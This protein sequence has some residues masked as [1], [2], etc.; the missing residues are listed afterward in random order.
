MAAFGAPVKAA[1]LWPP[2]SAINPLTG[3]ADRNPPANREIDGPHIAEWLST[4]HDRHVLPDAIMSVAGANNRMGNFVLNDLANRSRFID[5]NEGARELNDPVT[6]NAE[7]E[8]SDGA[9]TEP[10]RP[11]R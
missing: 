6:V 8:G 4:Y 10:H 7:A 2:V 1:R 5:F 3:G 9:V 11:V